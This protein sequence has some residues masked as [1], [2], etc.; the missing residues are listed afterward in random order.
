MRPSCL[1]F[2][3]FFFL[4]FALIRPVIA[5]CRPVKTMDDDFLRFGVSSF[6][7]ANINIAP[8]IRPFVL[9]W[10]GKLCITTSAQPK[11]H[12][13]SSSTSDFHLFWASIFPWWVLCTLVLFPIPCGCTYLYFVCVCAWRSLLFWYTSVFYMFASLNFPIF[14]LCLW[15]VDFVSICFK[16]QHL[17]SVCAWRFL[18]IVGYFCFSKCLKLYIP[19]F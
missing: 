11:D 6:F 5:L 18:F 14:R 3:F 16:V 8:L 10:N 19:S 17:S 1:G 7:S 13:L 9:W 4:L 12:Y 2:V 15:V